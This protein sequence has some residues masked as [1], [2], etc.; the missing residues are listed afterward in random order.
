ML[1]KLT[2]ITSAL[3]TAYCALIF[4]AN[5]ECDLSKLKGGLRDKY[6]AGCRAG[7][8]LVLLAPDVAK[9]LS[10]DL[11]MHQEKAEAAPTICG[12]T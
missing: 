3:P 12:P 4:N 7:T 8:N 9:H 2:L 6:V 10:E 1:Y 5:R 11:Y